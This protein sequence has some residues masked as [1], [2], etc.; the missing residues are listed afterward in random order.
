MLLEQILV[1]FPKKFRDFKHQQFLVHLINSN[2]IS[3]AYHS[4]QDSMIFPKDFVQKF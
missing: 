4:Y 2:K 3:L 1:F